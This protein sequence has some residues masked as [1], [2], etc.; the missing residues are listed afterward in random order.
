MSVCVWF[1]CVLSV[2]LPG[3][4]VVQDPGAAVGYVVQGGVRVVEG[5]GVVL[6]LD[7]VWHHVREP[8]GKHISQS[9]CRN[10]QELTS[11]FQYAVK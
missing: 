6:L 11:T 3:C 8:G 9:E 10:K 1:R 5:W 7:V 2:A 4:V